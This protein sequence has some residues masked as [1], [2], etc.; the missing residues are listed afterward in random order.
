MGELRTDKITHL[1]ID[2]VVTDD[3]DM[4]SRHCANFY[5]ALYN[6]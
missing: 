5:S 4:I 3:P 2:G 6:K 1:Y